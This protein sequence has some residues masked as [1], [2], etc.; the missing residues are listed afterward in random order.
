MILTRD[1]HG[2]QYYNG[3]YNSPTIG[4]CMHIP[5]FIF[6]RKYKYNSRITVTI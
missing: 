1:C 2:Y 5:D 3:P 6:F 4:N